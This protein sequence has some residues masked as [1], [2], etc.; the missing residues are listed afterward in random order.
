MTDDYENWNAALAA[1]FL[2]ERPGEPLYLYTDDAVLQEVA[3]DVGVDASGPHPPSA[4]RSWTR[5]AGRSPFVDG[6][7]RR[8]GLPK[9][10]R[11]VRRHTS[12][13]SASWSSSLSSARPLGSSTTPSSTNT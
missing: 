12:R 4:A 1:R 6:R 13:C 8:S 2:Q 5:F 11:L 3:G 10:M 9:V 7:S